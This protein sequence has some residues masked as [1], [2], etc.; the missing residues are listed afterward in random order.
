MD[1]VQI[2]KKHYLVT[3]RTAIIINPD[4]GQ[5][6]FIEVGLTSREKDLSSAENMTDLDPETKPMKT[7][8]ET[9]DLPRM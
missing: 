8:K 6:L 5:D 1:H 4:P 3:S 2:P 9:P 7:T